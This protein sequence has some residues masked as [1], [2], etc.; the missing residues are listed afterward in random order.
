MSNYTYTNNDLI[1]MQS[2]PFET[3]L[4]VTTAKFLEFCQK[5][6]YNVSLSFSG[7]QI[8]QFC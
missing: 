3:K 1:K 8:V 2:R 6:D 5:T 4:Q 7:G